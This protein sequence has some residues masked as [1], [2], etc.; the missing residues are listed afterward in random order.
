MIQSENSETDRNDG[1]R[2]TG[3]DVF[4]ARRRRRNVIYFGKAQSINGKRGDH[5]HLAAKY[6]R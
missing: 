5:G 4:C 6:K 1:E 2:E 3:E